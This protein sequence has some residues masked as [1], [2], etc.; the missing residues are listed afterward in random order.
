M[1]YSFTHNGLVIRLI[2]GA[3]I[4]ENPDNIDWQEY[5]RW[6]ASGGVTAPFVLSEEELLAHVTTETQRRLDDFA[7]TRMYDN[8]LS[9][10]TYASS[11]VPKFAA[12]GQR[13]VELRDQTWTKLYEVLDEIKAGTRPV[14]ASFAEIEPEL[15]V[16]SWSEST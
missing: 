10:C 8:I 14:P 11:A 6:V 13:A 3:T 15:P 1:A 7:R 16:L 12:E 2:D 9:A 5:Q 4:P